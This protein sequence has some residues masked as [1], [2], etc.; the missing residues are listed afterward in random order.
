MEYQGRDFV[1]WNK[2]SDC[3]KGIERPLDRA[4][5][6]EC[7]LYDFHD[8]KLNSWRAILITNN[9][10]DH[11]IVSYKHTSIANFVYCFPWNV[12]IRRET[13]RCSML[14]FELDSSRSFQT[15][16]IS[17]RGIT[18]RIISS[19][20]DQPLIKE[21]GS[22]HFNYNR[23]ANSDTIMLDRVQELTK[24]NG[25]LLI[26]QKMSVMVTKHGWIF[27]TT[28]I[29]AILLVALLLGLIHHLQSI[30]MKV[31]E[32]NVL[33]SSELRELKKTYEAA[34]CI[35]CRSDRGRTSQQTSVVSGGPTT[36]SGKSSVEAT[37]LDIPAKL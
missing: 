8:P 30:T 14:I 20:S 26:E 34:S 29:V 6:D 25:E 13:M 22:A 33:N 17:Y 7:P 18:R 19:Y 2:T 37:D 4:I 31:H 23:I 36:S 15:R 9:I 1:L 28:I 32:T 3:I 16:N 21:V 35:N 11:N 5:L 12:T 27:Y 10:Y 24:L